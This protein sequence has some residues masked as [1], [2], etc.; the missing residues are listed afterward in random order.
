[1]AILSRTQ[2]QRVFQQ[3]NT[4]SGSPTFTSPT[5]GTTAAASATIS[6][7]GAAIGDIVDVSPPTAPVAGLLVYGTV[8]AVGAVTVYA[9]NVSAGTLVPPVGLFRVATYPFTSEVA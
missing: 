3:V 1:M 6:V 8:T 9:A 4:G 2:F 5:T 7:P